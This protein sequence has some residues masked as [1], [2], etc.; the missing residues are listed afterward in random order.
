MKPGKKLFYTSKVHL[1]NFHEIF[2]G[3]QALLAL[4]EHTSNDLDVIQNECNAAN[5]LLME[6]LNDR[7]LF[8]LHFHFDLHECIS[9]EFKLDFFNLLLF[10]G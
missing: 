2:L 1:Y 9:G 6:I 4:L 3:N 5:E 8:I 7:F 10:F